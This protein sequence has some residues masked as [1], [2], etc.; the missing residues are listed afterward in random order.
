VKVVFLCSSLEPGRDGV[1]DYT[2]RL[3]A[4]LVRQGHFSAVVSL[5]DKYIS[6]VFNDIQQSEGT[7]LAVLRLPSVWP[8]KARIGYAKKIY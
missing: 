4:E 6:D 7:K 1:G 2:R 5:N 3:A 8:M